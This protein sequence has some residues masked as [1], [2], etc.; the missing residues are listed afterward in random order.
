MYNGLV[1]EETSF[2]TQSILKI[3]YISFNNKTLKNSNK[4][5]F[6]YKNECQSHS[7]SL[8]ISINRKYF[9]I[10]YINPLISLILEQGHVYK[11]VLKKIHLN[12]QTTKLCDH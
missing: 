6:Q 11:I 12:F 8:E 5:N 9:L 10:L 4:I 1:K 7:S 2:D 3:N